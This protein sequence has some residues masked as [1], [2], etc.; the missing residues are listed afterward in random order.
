MKKNGS[1]GQQKTYLIALKLAQ[2]EF[3]KELNGFLPILLLD[4]IFDKLDQNRVEQII[5][6]VSGNNFGQIFIT[7]T[8]RER[9]NN[10]LDRTGLNFQFLNW[11]N[12]PILSGYSGI[13]LRDNLIL[14][15]FMRKSN[16]QKIGEVISDYLKELRIDK[17]VL[18][19]R[20]I[21]SWPSVVG[22][23]IARQTE[24]FIFVM[25]YFMFM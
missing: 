8:S 6:L 23:T 21:N 3:I 24:K 1:Q 17:K 12:L 16:T 25:V 18:E 15:H 5:K 19:A 11:N 7:D 13:N 4:D 2:F 9:M 22:L 14:E 20:V 10:I